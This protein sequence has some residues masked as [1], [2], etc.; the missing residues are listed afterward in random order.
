MPR[1]GRPKL[2]E[3]R[4]KKISLRVSEKDYDRIFAYAKEHKM[5]VADLISRAMEDY[6]SKNP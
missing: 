3:P 4:N 5:T 6:L 1:N 2:K